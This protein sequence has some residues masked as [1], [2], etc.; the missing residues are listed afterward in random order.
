MATITNIL[1]SAL[2]S[3]HANQVGISVTSN[4]IANRNDL[5]YARQRM[6]TVP[7]IDLL[8]TSGGLGVQVS[9]I[10]SLRDALIERRILQED[11]SRGGAETLTNALSD[12]E[13]YFTDGDG[14]GLQQYITN[15]FNSFQTLSSD[16]S[17]T[18]FRELV[19][20]SGQAMTDAFKQ[21]RGD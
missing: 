21:L 13:V 10:E 12:I 3:M 20:T 17:S 11:S 14:H 7:A 6:V 5:N 15:F 19:R 2:S 4:N 18:S 16:P 1:S 9:H 8:G